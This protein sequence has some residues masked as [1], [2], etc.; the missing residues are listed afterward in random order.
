MDC[1]HIALC[2]QRISESTTEDTNYSMQS[3]AALTNG[4]I[5]ENFDSINETSGRSNGPDQRL[6]DLV[7]TRAFNNASVI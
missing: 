1:L 2:M 4:T 3:I 7:D 6:K 5:K